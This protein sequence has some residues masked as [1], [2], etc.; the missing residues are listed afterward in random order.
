MSNPKTAI[1]KITKQTQA[2]A[3]KV[4]ERTK[5]KIS[6][7]RTRAKASVKR[8]TALIDR[9]H[10]LPSTVRKALR[11]RVKSSAQAKL[12]ATIGDLKGRQAT[13]IYNIRL[14]ANERKAA[15]RKAAKQIA[16]QEKIP[17][18]KAIKK[19][20]KTLEKRSGVKIKHYKK[21]TKKDFQHVKD[22]GRIGLGLDYPIPLDYASYLSTLQAARKTGM[23]YLYMV[24]LSTIANGDTHIK[25]ALNVYSFHIDVTLS[26][27]KLD[28]MVQDKYNVLVMEYKYN[29]L[30]IEGL[31]M[32]F[33]IKTGDK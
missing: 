33:T 11:D 20:P 7:E 17:Y 1:G 24:Y 30:Q 4:R 10:W 18:K 6:Q 26:K 5:R 2:R 9:Q 22:K 32:H 8:Q 31:I 12:N 25:S 21:P 13:E 14:E 27:E 15:V 23:G 3:S 16:K 28:Q 29:N 19:A